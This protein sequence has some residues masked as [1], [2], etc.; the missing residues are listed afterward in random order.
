MS[1]TR[2]RGNVVRTSKGLQDTLFD[3]IDD[4]RNGRTTPQSART[5]SSLAGAIIQTARLEIDYARFIS[6]SRGGERAATKAIEFGS[7]AAE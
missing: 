4:M 1:E 3:E 6:E 5:V 7:E 2:D